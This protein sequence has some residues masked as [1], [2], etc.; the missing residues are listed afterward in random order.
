MKI[1]EGTIMK[2]T[3]GYDQTNVDF[4]KVT[5]VNNGWAWMQPVGQVMVEQ[6][7]YLSETVIPSNEPAG[8][9]FRRKIQSYSMGDY[10][11]I[12]SYAGASIWS[13]QPVMQT[14]TH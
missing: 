3:W 10:V 4:F 14:H 2:S 7:G 9:V 1:Q 11:R 8:K 12:N 13:G 6:T 5:K